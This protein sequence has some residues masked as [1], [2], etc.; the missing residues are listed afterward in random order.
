MY[1]LSVVFKQCCVRFNL[2]VQCNAFKGIGCN[3]VYKHAIKNVLRTDEQTERT[4]EPTKER[5]SRKDRKIESRTL[6]SEKEMERNSVTVQRAMT[7]HRSAT[8]STQFI[9]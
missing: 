1:A 7:M 4:S 8:A 5:R 2:N 9:C 3:G 6:K